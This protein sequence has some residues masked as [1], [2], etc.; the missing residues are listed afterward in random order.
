[1]SWPDALSFSVMAVCLCIV[2]C[3]FID[4]QRSR[5]ERINREFRLGELEHRIRKLEAPK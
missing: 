3:W 4:L 1:M 2:G 5:E